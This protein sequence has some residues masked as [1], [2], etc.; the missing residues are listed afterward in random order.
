MKNKTV[1]IEDGAASYEKET[2]FTMYQKYGCPPLWLLME[3]D[4]E[5]R[6]RLLREE[7]KGNQEARQRK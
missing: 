5:R 1:L 7:K 4:R 2:F 6:E 3:S